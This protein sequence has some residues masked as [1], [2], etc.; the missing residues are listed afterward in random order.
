M[1]ELID[2]YVTEFLSNY[3]EPLVILTTLGVILG[4]YFY[5]IYLVIDNYEKG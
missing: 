1:Q 3:F 4:A 2:N 5:F